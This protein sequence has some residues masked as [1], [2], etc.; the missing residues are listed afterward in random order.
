MVMKR[1][2]FKLSETKDER[3]AG[4]EWRCEWK[5]KWT[6]G[7]KARTSFVLCSSSSSPF[8]HTTFYTYKDEESTL[9]IFLQLNVMEEWSTV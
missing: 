1:G 6:E 9:F 8:I 5:V 3:G 2:L 4:T 7:N